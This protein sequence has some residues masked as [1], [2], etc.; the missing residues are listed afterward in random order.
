M[1]SEQLFAELLRQGFLGLVITALITGWLVPR[2]VVD[3]YR[4]REARKNAIIERQAK[5]IERLAGRNARIADVPDGPA[6]A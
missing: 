1:N 6:D 4:D 5:V 2:W 3:E